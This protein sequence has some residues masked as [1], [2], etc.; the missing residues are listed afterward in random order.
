M[1]S[2]LQGS[3]GFSVVFVI[4][5]KPWVGRGNDRTGSKMSLRRNR[6]SR[7]VNASAGMSVVRIGVII[8]VLLRFSCGSM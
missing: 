3:Y 6:A 8:I 2:L 4:Q 5:I 1:V 7:L